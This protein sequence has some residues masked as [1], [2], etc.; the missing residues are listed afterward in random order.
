MSRNHNAALSIAV[1]TMLSATIL[2]TA[3]RG[4]VVAAAAGPQ[5]VSP[6]FQQA[7]SNIHQA[8]WS[9]P[10][11][12]EATTPKATP[13]AALAAAPA[14][15]SMPALTDAEMNKL[16]LYLQKVG[17]DVPFEQAITQLIGVT[18]PGQTMTFRQLN[19]GDDN[20]TVHIHFFNRSESD[21]NIV[22]FTFQDKSLNSIHGYLTDPQFHYIRGYVSTN[23]QNQMLSKKVGEAGFAAE[24]GWWAR[25]MDAAPNP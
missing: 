18:A 7:L 1:S 20:D 2:S 25:E 3:P 24:V 6:A 22:L 16:N 23:G 11:D 8:G 15:K 5:A 12:A 13:V 4:S 10:A 9:V 17:N 21:A 14:P 19:G